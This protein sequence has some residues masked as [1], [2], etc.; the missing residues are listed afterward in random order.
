MDD[1]LGFISGKIT[2][3]LFVIIGLTNDTAKQAFVNAYKQSQSYKSHNGGWVMASGAT[4]INVC[5]GGR[6]V[7]FGKEVNSPP[8]GQGEVVQPKHIKASLTLVKQAVL[9][10]LVLVYIGQ[11]I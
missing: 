5:L 4:V 8:L 9:L 7:Y 3:I 10:W 6:A 2:A 11:Y 1:L